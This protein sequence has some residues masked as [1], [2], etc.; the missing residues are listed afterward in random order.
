VGKLVTNVADE[1]AIAEK[2]TV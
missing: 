2:G 1:Q